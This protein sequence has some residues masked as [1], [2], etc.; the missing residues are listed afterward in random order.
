MKR[1]ILVLAVA[2]LMAVMMV[3]MAAP[4][5]AKGPSFETCFRVFIHTGHA[6]PPCE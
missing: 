2:A 3:A 4:A 6:P 5:F 1:F